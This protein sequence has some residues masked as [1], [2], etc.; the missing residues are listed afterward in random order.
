MSHGIQK[1][2][3]I[4]I[5]GSVQHPVGQN[6]LYAELC[7]VLCYASC[8][9]LCLEWNAMGMLDTAFGVFCEG[10]ATNNSLQSLDL[11]NN[12]IS[13]DGAAE[14]GGALRRNATLKSLGG[15]CVK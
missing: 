7:T 1:H 10:L 2:H 14:F 13:H 5:Y 11:R 4:L 15:L 8:G 3:L 9:S 6:W 12:Q